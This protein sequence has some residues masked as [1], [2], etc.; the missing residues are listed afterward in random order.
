MALKKILEK[1]DEVE[2]QF[3]SLY[4]E[5]DGKFYLDVEGGL[6]EGAAK[7]LEEERKA[8]KALEAK[9]GKLKDVDPEEYNRLKTEAEERD[10]KKAE[11]KGEFDKI[12]AKN[13]EQ[14]Q[15]D[16]DAANQKAEKYKGSL[17]DTLITNEALAA[18]TA[19]KG[20][21]DLLLPVLKPRLKFVEAEDESF[22][23]EV[24]DAKGEPMVTKDGPAKA[25]ELVKEL[26][27]S[28]VFGRAFDGTDT[29]GGGAGPG[30]NG[31]GGGRNPWAKGFE[32]ETEQMKLI[33]NNPAQARALAQSAGINIESL[34]PVA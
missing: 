8:K 12:L 14:F 32:N 11:E 13:K 23:V 7:A 19:E 34:I 20:I 26:K 27:A 24:L 9:L 16:L 30:N 1:L 6:G 18:V 3:R 31:G 29:G 4:V 28:P 2:E 5:K 25:I 17:A 22:R 15:K 33:A 21:P 10:R